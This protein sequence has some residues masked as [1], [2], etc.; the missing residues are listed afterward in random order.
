MSAE[1]LNAD[2]D[3]M[4]R[5]FC[6]FGYIF[7]SQVSPYPV[8]E[9]ED[10]DAEF[11]ES[12]PDFEETLNDY[13]LREVHQA[14]LDARQKVLE[15]ILKKETE[16]EDIFANTPETNLEIGTRL[17]A[18]TSTGNTTQFEMNKRLAEN[19]VK[20]Q[21]KQQERRQ[22]DLEKKKKAKQ[23][24][25]RKFQAEIK[26]DIELKKKMQEEDKKV[27]QIYGAAR[28]EELRRKR[29]ER[30][31]RKEEEIRLTEEAMRTVD[32]IAVKSRG[33][34]FTDEDIQ[35]EM[36]RQKNSPKSKL[37]RMKEIS[38]R[39]KEQNKAE[40]EKNPGKPLSPHRKSFR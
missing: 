10:Q 37:E 20:R 6:I 34:R 19:T 23:E 3:F 25:I 33:L 36:E 11:T 4:R 29:E 14:D 9:C 35:E 24:S 13:L 15:D 38:Q 5:A 22:A 17:A 39:I 28:A 16:L 21:Q 31:K 2:A 7:D 32:E 26:A 12:L 27:K 1:E 18:R 8:T 40:S 30:E